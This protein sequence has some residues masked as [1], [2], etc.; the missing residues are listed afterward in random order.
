MIIRVVVIGLSCHCLG[1]FIRKS[2]SLKLRQWG[3][4][5]PVTLYLSAHVC[6]DDICLYA[7]RSW[8]VWRQGSRS[9]VI[10]VL[11]QPVLY[12]TQGWLYP[13]DIR[14]TNHEKPRNHTLR[15]VH[16]FAQADGTIFARGSLKE[17]DGTHDS[18]DL[19]PATQCH[20]IY[21]YQH[22]V[23]LS[24]SSPFSEVKCISN[25]AEQVLQQ[26]ESTVDLRRSSFQVAIP[27]PYPHPHMKIM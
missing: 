20:S 23:A 8:C 24:P 27:S 25:V 11:W 26:T 19:T 17:G 22:T 1:K 13:T 15:F 7:W 9:Y 3:L 6:I 4:A 12:G 10:D 14:P 18:T 21:L 5:C 2:G 16:R